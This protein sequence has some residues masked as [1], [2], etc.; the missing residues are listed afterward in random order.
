MGTGAVTLTMDT[1]TH[2]PT[3]SSRSLRI[4]SHVPYTT[5]R[6]MQVVAPFCESQDWRGYDGLEIWVRGDGGDAPPGGGE[7]SIVLVDA[8]SP[9]GDEIWQ[10]TRWVN[11]ADPWT[12]I[13][14][15]LT[16]TTTLSDVVVADPWDH[17]RDFVIPEWEKDRWRDGVLDVSAIREIWIKSLTVVADSLDYPALA[18]WV[19][20]ATLLT[21]MPPCAPPLPVGYDV[22]RRWHLEGGDR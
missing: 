15:A 3:A 1:S 4:E 22:A 5:G 2:A 10:S 14:V 17:P 8:S 6:Y 7:F 11:R 20:D 12:R 9:A 18:V 19:D 13:D 16:G 21:S